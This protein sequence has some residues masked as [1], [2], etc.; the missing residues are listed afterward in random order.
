MKKILCI[1]DDL[2][3]ASIIELALGDLYDV[4]IV[5]DTKDVM[6]TLNAF[7]PDL[8]LI[9]NYIGM[10]QAAEVIKEI[11]TSFLFRN[12]PF[13]LCS[14]HVDIK[15]I[16][17]EISASAYLEKPFDLVELYAIVDQVLLTIPAV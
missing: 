10:V 3:F 1:E 16:A 12:I 9:D 14:G 5:T 2:D 4:K 6:E 7:I 13:I 15:K 8:I 17:L 11:K